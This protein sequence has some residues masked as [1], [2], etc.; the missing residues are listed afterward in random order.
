MQLFPAGQN[1]QAV[2]L[3]A[4]VN[5]FVGQDIINE[6]LGAIYIVL[7][8]VQLSSP[9]R[10]YLPEEQFEELPPEQLFPAWQGAHPILL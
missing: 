2:L 4:N 8:F 7:A 10:E 5:M 3:F 9:R 6:V 1:S